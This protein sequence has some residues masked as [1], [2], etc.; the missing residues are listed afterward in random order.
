MI[1]YRGRGTCPLRASPAG[2]DDVVVTARRRPADSITNEFQCQP[3]KGEGCQKDRQEPL[4]RASEGDH[5]ALD[6]VEGLSAARL[7]SIADLQGMTSE[8]DWYL[9]LSQP[10]NLR[11]ESSLTTRIKTLWSTVRPT[12]WVVMRSALPLRS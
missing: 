3:G 9:G 11:P 7:S 8:I 1:Q 4:A 2:D 6:G 12:G 10:P 5:L